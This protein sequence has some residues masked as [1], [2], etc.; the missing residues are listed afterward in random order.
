MTLSER[1][2][3]D[4]KQALK[5]GEK[6][7]LETLRTL[8]AQ[9]LELT[10]RGPAQPVTNDDELS[11]LLS[12]IKKRREAI[13]VYQQAGRKELVQKETSELEII[14]T[15]LPS[16]LS[17]EEADREIQ[18]IVK[19]TGASSPKDFGRVMA[20]AMRELKGRFDGKAVQEIVKQKLG[21]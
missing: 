2:A 17:R 20:V 14:Q 18:N 7:K 8:R 19:Q 16:Q 10:K 9:F 6:L 3:E 11:V 21:G 5:A 4:M 13:D 12:A 15:Y 1:I